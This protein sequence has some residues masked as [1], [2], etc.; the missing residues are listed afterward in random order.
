M[1]EQLTPPPSNEDF[2][3]SNE[4]IKSYKY[5]SVFNQISYY[6]SKIAP[7]LIKI[8]N[9]IIYYSIKFIK[10]VVTSMINMVFKGGS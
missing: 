7:T 4:E 10:S 6:F 9:G 2:G 3:M 1:D 8:L 5:K